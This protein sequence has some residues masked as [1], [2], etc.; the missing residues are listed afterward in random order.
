METFQSIV[1]TFHTVFPD[2]TLWRVGKGDC[3]LIGSKETLDVDYEQINTRINSQEIS[4][5]FARIGI[6]TLP[7]IFSLYVMGSEGIQKFSNR[8][9]MTMPL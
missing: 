7:E 9:E 5:D 3:I 2:M 1:H 8:A 6:R 4:A